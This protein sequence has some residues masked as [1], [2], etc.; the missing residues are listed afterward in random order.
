[1][2]KREFD[3]HKAHI[4]EQAE[5]KQE[6]ADASRD[7]QLAR[8][9]VQNGWSPEK[10]VEHLEK[11]WKKKVSPDWVVRL[12]L[13]GRFLSCFDEVAVTI[14]DRAPLANLT[15][16]SFRRLWDAQARGDEF[17]RFSLVREQLERTR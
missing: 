4:D 3:A 16:Q 14:R 8:L 6:G 10:L 9:F 2:N 1:M 11:N 13:F 5:A 15:E 12:L 7:Q 17:H